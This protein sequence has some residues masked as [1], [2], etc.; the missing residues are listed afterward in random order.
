MSADPVIKP[1]RYQPP[2]E[3]RARR[4][5]LSAAR[6]VLL[7][8]ALTA[9]AVLAFLFMARSVALEFTPPASRISIVG[10]PAVEFGG[11]HLLLSGTYE[12]Q[13]ELDGHHPIA[14]PFT[15]GEERNQ[16]FEFKFA[17]LPGLLTV[18]A[19][20][21]G[22]RLTVD[23]RPLGA[24]PLTDVPVEAGRR[25]LRFTH[26][27]HQ[28]LDMTLA[29]AGRSER[30]RIDAE[31]LPNWGEVRY[32]TEPPGA[33]ILVDGEDTGLRTPAT[34]EILAGEHEVALVMQ[35]HQSHRER[36]LIAPLEQREA[37]LIRLRQSD[38]QLRVST[39]PER[40]GVTIDGQYRG[41]TPVSAALRSGN[42]YRV[43]LFKAGFAA[44]SA[45]VT[46][47]AGEN[48]RVSF[49]LEP[50]TGL[51]WVQA[52][53][54]NAQLLVD[55][56]AKGSANQVLELPTRPHR[57]EI[58]ADGY[59]GYRTEIRPRQGL[60][61]EVRVKLLTLAEARLA[62]LRPEVATAQGQV[63]K[64]FKPTPI[65]MGASRREPG[66]RANE[67]LRDVALERFFYLGLKEVTNAEFKA[68]ASG[69]DSGAYEDQP[70][71][72]DDQPVAMVSWHEAARY[73]NWLS[74]QDGLPAFYAE[75][76]GKVTGFNA[77]ATGYRLP[78]EAEWAW[79]A[80]HQEDGGLLRFPWGEA[81]PPPNR[82]GNYADRSAGHL[83]GRIIFGYNDNH[84]VAAPVGTFAANAKGIFDLGGNVAEWVNDFYQ[85]PA[86]DPTPP[87]GP[88][89]GEYHVI[90][91]SSWMHG[92]ATDLRLS[93][94]DYGI[95][96]RRDLGFRLARFAETEQ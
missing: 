26:P 64:L 96:G 3:S 34:A 93:F 37:P 76:F 72:K 68:F 60:T 22:A 52:E 86:P 92:T 81:L 69:H 47:K 75:E 48:R 50:L 40:A 9:A 67:T 74:S 83:V 31:L 1:V 21:T 11:V 87:L 65:R 39:R 32:V 17:P 90:R 42:A 13:A 85:H 27:R 16:A 53:P 14:A 6:M 66:R 45:T 49:D 10:G 29:V 88:P 43:R 33:R 82:H 61:Q 63:L 24:T 4:P 20:P 7:A 94:R 62:A 38:A 55:G 80:R 35:G 19:V 77:A 12:V 23:G 18:E 58:Q 70:L 54:A 30:Q 91:G 46:L 59:A 5:R 2:G 79:T 57:L 36:I 78:S 44:H 8:A 71:N 15:V 28:A 25:E 84:A 73:C 56:Q 51:V 95:D 89:A 41:E